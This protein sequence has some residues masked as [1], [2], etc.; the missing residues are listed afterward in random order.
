MP[1]TLLAL[2]ALALGGYLVLQQSRHE[3]QTA[4]AVATEQVHA[5]AADV[6]RQ[7]FA[8]FESL[9]FDEATA[10]GR[11]LASATNLSLPSTFGAAAGGAA[12]TAANDLDDFAGSVLTVR[13][14][15]GQD[16]VAFEVDT[17]VVYLAEDGTDVE[18][19]VQTRLKKVTLT[20]RPR[21]AGVEP[22]V[23]SQLFVCGSPCAF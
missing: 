5:A 20:L 17:R 8:F 18:S 14:P 16:T 6:A 1:Q 19:A 12:E 7:R 11:G 2:L 10:I 3:S 9:A 15:V 22:V 13:Q 23:L 4:R 21:V